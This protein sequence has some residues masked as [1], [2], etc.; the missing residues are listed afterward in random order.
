M[1]FKVQDLCFTLGPDVALPNLDIYKPKQNQ[2][3]CHPLPTYNHK[4]G[5]RF[6]SKLSYL[7]KGKIG[8]HMGSTGPQ[9]LWNRD[10]SASFSTRVGNSPLFGPWLCSLGQRAQSIVLHSPALPPV[11][12]FFPPF[13]ATSEIVLPNMSS[14]LTHLLPVES[15][16]PR[17]FWSISKSTS[18]SSMA[19]LLQTWLLKTCWIF[20]AVNYSHSMCQNPHCSFCEACL[21]LDLITSTLSS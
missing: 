13:G 11:W 2:G 4:T 6:S 8:R 3:I 17:A 10:I 19:A 20:D 5:T 16:D 12:F 7:K 1:G 18:S 15:W 21:S 9:T 14:S